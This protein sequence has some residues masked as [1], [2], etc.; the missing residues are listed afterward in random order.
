MT[1]F[2]WPKAIRVQTAEIAGELVA[3]LHAAG[4]VLLRSGAR[5]FGNIVATALVVEA[6]AIWVGNSMVGEISVEN[7]IPN[8]QLEL[9]RH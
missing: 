2:R 4:T 3:N 7:S 5:L 6:G 1:N 9:A 8:R